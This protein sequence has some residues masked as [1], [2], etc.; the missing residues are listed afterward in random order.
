VYIVEEGVL[1]AWVLGLVVSVL[2]EDWY[3]VWCPLHLVVVVLARRHECA[4]LAAA[5]EL[6]E[7]FSELV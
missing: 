1:S 5:L 4:D 6:A 2:V 3:L 7:R